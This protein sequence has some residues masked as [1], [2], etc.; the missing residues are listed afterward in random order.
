MFRKMFRE[1]VISAIGSALR[2]LAILLAVA[3]LACPSAMLAQRG[4]GG[5]GH[6]GGSAAG[7]GA[8]GSGGRATGVDAKDDLRGFHEALAVQAS[9]EQILAFAAMLKSTAAASSELQAFV[10]QLNKPGN[11]SE[12]AGHDKTLGDALGTAR[13]LNKKFVEG[14]SEPQK[15]GLKE[16]TKKLI[17][18]DSELAQQARMLDQ[19]FEAKASGPQ[20]LSSA[21]GLERAL[22]SFQHEQIDLG[23]EM[24]IDASNNA[25]DSTFNLP[26]VK[27]LINV[28]NEPVAITTSGVVSK[29]R[30]GAGQNTFSVEVVADMAD[31]QDNITGVLRSR[32]NRANRCGEQVEIQ[33]AALTPQGA[34]GVVVAL[35]HYE[36]WTCTTMLGRENLNEIVEG[37]GT[38]E[39]KLA[40]A[41]GEDGTL[42]LLAQIGRVEAE[43]LVG[44][45]LRSG[46]VGEGL[47][48]KI[49]ESIL[50]IISQGAD[51]RT[52]LPAGARGYA[53]L[54]RAQFQGTGLGKLTV[55]LNGDIRVPNENLAALTTELKQQ[56]SQPPEPS[57]ARPELISR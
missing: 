4:G 5:G 14:F 23:G 8:M 17:K 15:S 24:S 11:A 1:G 13:T 27:N 7:G 28:A 45:L 51:F 43:G 18:A 55:M 26:P 49:A 46:P 39:V 2:G 33:T 54:R 50:A 32:V 37:N 30:I 10:E 25:Q 47:R 48:D 31:L 9:R 6:V 56:S 29:S 40:P 57:S 38:I 35:V 12:V 52:A 41:V 34:A 19:A 22:A 21:Q 3:L 42:R 36:R 44:D 16:V 20:L 53:T